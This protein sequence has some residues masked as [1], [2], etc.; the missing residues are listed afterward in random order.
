MASE[1]FE[2][3]VKKDVRNNPI[4]REV[5]RERH[6][7]MFRSLF[8]GLSSSCSCSGPGSS[9]VPA[10]RLPVRADERAVEE[11]SIVT[12]LEIRTLSAP[13]SSSARPSSSWVW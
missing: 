5:D 3:A 9:R 13:A 4:V 8:T 7:D 6:K 10:L 2:Y 11:E 12:S 1:S